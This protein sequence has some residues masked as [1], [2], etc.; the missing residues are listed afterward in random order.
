MCF[1]RRKIKN[2][3]KT[4]GKFNGYC[5]FISLK[6]KLSKNSATE[7]LSFGP[8]ITSA[9][10]LTSGMAFGSIHQLNKKVNETPFN[11]SLAINYSV[12]RATTGSLRA[13]LLEGIIPEN[14]VRTTLIATSITAVMTGSCALRLPIPVRW[15]R[16]I[17]MGMHSR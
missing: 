4:F 9:A 13:A 7:S 1:S 14:I 17:F 6:K 16:S 5:E 11:G 2:P 8:I 3:E 15:C 10:A 12:R